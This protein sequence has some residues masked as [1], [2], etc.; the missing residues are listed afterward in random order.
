MDIS[1]HFSCSY[2]TKIVQTKKHKTMKVTNTTK[3]DAAAATKIGEKLSV[4]LADMHIFYANLRGYHW[5]VKGN[6]F[7]ELHKYF[8]DQ[9]NAYATHI[10]DVAERMLQ[11]DVTPTS[12]LSEY[13]KVATIKEECSCKC[14]KEMME[15]VLATIGSLIASERAIIALADEAHD[16]ATT[17]LLSAILDEQE[18]A[19]WMISAYLS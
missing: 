6:L 7:F 10:D 19:C 11:L 2:V 5:N 17:D 3:V 13:L 12:H 4:L 1:E 15:N 9:Y 14:G 18:K 16:T 8:E